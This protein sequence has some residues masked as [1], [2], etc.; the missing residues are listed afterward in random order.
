MTCLNHELRSEF[1]KTTLANCKRNRVP[2]Q[3]LDARACANA[4]H[5]SDATE[6]CGESWARCGELVAI[7]GLSR[8]RSASFGA[9]NH[10]DASA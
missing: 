1:A 8:L 5:L 3:A 7:G 2:S 10:V 4:I 6:S 9:E